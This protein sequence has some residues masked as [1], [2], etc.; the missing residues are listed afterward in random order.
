MNVA[1]TVILCSVFALLGFSIGCFMCLQKISELEFEKSALTD[2]LQAS[3][4]ANTALVKENEEL[5]GDI[6]AVINGQ[7]IFASTL[8]ADEI[9][10]ATKEE[11]KTD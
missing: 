6:E 7:H 1:I 10:S 3:R 5:R 9:Y 4:S 11:T 2:W 8:S